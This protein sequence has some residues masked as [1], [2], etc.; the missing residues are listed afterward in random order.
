MA[1][2]KDECFIL[3]NHFFFF[4]FCFSGRNDACFTKVVVTEG[5]A[6]WCSG[7]ILFTTLRIAMCEVQ[8]SDQ[9][10]CLSGCE[11]CHSSSLDLHFWL[12]WS[13]TLNLPPS[14]RPATSWV[15]WRFSFE[16]SWSGGGGG[17]GPHTHT[18]T[19]TMWWHPLLS[20]WHKSGLYGWWPGKRDTLR[21]LT[22]NTE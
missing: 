14:S 16:F 22:A 5:A 2:F 7:K 20:T 1:N 11:T 12:S 18:R 19:N 4:L 6:Q 21:K 3:L 15:A 13:Q 8:M 10:F 17:R 9:T